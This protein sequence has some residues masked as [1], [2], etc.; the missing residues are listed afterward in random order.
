M[1]T[2]TQNATGFKVPCPHCGATEGLVIKV[3]D[4]AVECSE[5]SEEVTRADLARLIEDARRLLRWLD[6]AGTV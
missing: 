5:C 2:T 4:L 3:N 6:A 1:A